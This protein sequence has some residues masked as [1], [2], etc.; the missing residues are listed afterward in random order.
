MTGER[1]E[2]EGQETKE[3]EQEKGVTSTQAQ[4]VAFKVA[5]FKG[6]Q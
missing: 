6:A 1:R 3:R 4:L 5:L 2:E